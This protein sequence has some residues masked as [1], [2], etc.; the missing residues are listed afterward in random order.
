MLQTLNMYNMPN[1]GLNILKIVNFI[2]VF[3]SIRAPLLTSEKMFFFIKAL[4]CHNIM[5]A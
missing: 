5:F 2:L 4:F 1:I 3:Y